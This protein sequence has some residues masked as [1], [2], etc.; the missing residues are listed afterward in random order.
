MHDDANYAA[1]EAFFVNFVNERQGDSL[2]QVLVQPSGGHL[3]QVVWQLS[4]V[5]ALVT[6]RLEKRRGVCECRP[7]PNNWL[8]RMKIAR[9]LTGSSLKYSET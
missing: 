9:Y 8:L 3:H 4:A 2:V 5:L 1:L 7:R 6:N